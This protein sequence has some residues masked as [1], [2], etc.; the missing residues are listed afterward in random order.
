MLSRETA[1][2]A[3]LADAEAAGSEAFRTGKTRVPAHDGGMT[4]LLRK[5]EGQGYAVALLT[6]WLRGWDRANLAPPPC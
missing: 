4:A 1:P 5:Y 6:A 2:L 3:I